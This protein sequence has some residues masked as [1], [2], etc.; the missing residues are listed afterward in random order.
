MQQYVHEIALILILS[1]H[2]HDRVA[3]HSIIQQRT[4]EKQQ[5]YSQRNLRMRCPLGQ[6]R[7]LSLVISVAIEADTLTRT[8]K[9]VSIY[10]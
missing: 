7:L 1:Y 4:I 8:D 9:K 5:I 6:M 10:L 3:M 2:N